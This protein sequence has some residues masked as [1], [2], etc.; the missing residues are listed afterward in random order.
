MFGGDKREYRL[1]GIENKVVVV[2][3]GAMGLGREIS[4]VF[5]K[6]GAKV[7]IIDVSEA[8]GVKASEE[9]DADGG[10]AAFYV[11][12]VSDAE[13]IRG[14]MEQIEG[15][16]GGIDTLVS[17]AGITAKTSFVDLELEAW[18]RI[19]EVNRTGTF[20]CSKAVL[21]YLQKRG[22]GVIIMMSSGSAITGTGGSAAYAASKGGINSLVRSLSRELA[23]EGIRVNGVAPRS[24]NLGTFGT[25]YTGEEGKELVKMI[26]LGRLGTADDI[27]HVVAFLASDLSGFITGETILVDG[28]RTYCG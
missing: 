25:L 24:I 8:E 12:D 20:V 17:N 26:P 18:K 19:I 11:G 9:I 16:F 1:P 21:P 6:L 22:G 28:G 13:Q 27:A 10:E 2:T 7:G 23:P 4:M 14:C 15:R 3:G 5:G